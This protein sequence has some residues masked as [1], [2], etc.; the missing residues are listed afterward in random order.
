MVSSC[1]TGKV[2]ERGE[3]MTDFGVESLVVNDLTEADLE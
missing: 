3:M 1:R 2:A